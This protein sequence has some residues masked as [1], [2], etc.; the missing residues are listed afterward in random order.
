MKVVINQ[1]N[2]ENLVFFDQELTKK[3]ADL[4]DLFQTWQL[5]VRIPGLRPTAQ[6]TLLLFLEKVT[7]KHIEIIKNHL[8]ADE[9]IIEKIDHHLVRNYEITENEI[10][11]GY[12]NFFIYRKGE[13]LYIS[14]WR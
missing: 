6:K 2:V 10:P 13:Q 4:S 5:G 1:K 12:D 9:V 8:H 14:F 7:D 11:D 3:L